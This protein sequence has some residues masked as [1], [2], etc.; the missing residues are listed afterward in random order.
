VAGRFQGQEAP[1]VIYS[2]TTSRHAGAPRGMG[3][4]YSLNRLN[5]A[6]SR[7]KALS[8][9]VRSPALFDA[10]ALD[11]GTAENHKRVLKGFEVGR[12][13]VAPCIPA[14]HAKHNVR[15]A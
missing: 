6:T 7:A 1:I 15:G 4:I 13:S 11:A 14:I 3:L 12:A 2:M 8:F 5:V 9:L 10:G